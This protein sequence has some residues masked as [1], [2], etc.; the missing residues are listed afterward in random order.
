MRARFVE[1][2]PE[3]FEEIEQADA[4]E[5]VAYG[6]AGERVR[7]EFPSAVVTEVQAGWEDRWREFHRPVRIGPLWIGPPW[8]QAPAGMLGVVIDPG[9][10]FG[11]G[12]HAT[13]RLC[14]ELLLELSPG[15]LLDVGCGSGVLS[16]AAARLGFAQVTAVDSDVAAVEA[17]KANA[18]ANGVSLETRQLDALSGDLPI[19][20]TAVAN[21]ALAA[22]EA[23]A[24]RLAVDHLIT[25][26]YLMR[27]EP[28]IVGFVHAERRELDGWA[29]DLYL[30]A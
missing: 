15:S 8:E 5:L 19:A 12:A 16:I 18:V 10:A 27:D 2:A 17:A 23:L 24:P 29:A 11:T 13:T 25:S 3:G 26:G 6:E 21:I 1:L 7:G 30:R 22:V 14:V 28:A 20:E 9:R 4:V